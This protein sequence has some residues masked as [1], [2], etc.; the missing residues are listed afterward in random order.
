MLFNTFQFAIFLAVVLAGYRAVPRDRRASLLLAA[1]LVFYAFWIPAYLLLMLADVGVNY[2]LLR[3]MVR[4]RRPRLI[5]ACSITFTLGLLA[6]FKY[7]AF[8]VQLAAPALDG[9]FGYAPQVPDVL[10]PLGISF[11]S[12]QII[13]LAVDTYRGAR[14]PV[15][16]LGRYALF[17]SF[18]PQLI[19]GPI[20]R[21]DQLLPQLAR[22]GE[23]TPERN[24]RGLWLITSGLAKKVVLADFLIAGFVD[25]VFQEP[26]VGSGAFHL[27]AVYSFAFQIYFDFSG[28]TDMARGIA[29]LLGFELPKNFTEPYLSRNP[30]ELWERWHITL[31]S[32]LRDYLY[33]PLGGN[34][35]GRN[36]T[37]RNLMVTMLLGGLWHGAGWNF[38]IWGGIHGVL[39]AGHR[40]WVGRRPSG[41]DPIV[42]R[43]VLKIGL[44]FQGICFAWVFFRART[45]SD[46]L[47]V[48]ESI[49]TGSYGDWPLLQ[50]GVVI[51]CCG[52]HCAERLLR[53]RLPAV[54][55]A[56]GRRCWGAFAEAVVMGVVL[57]LAVVV[58]D[59][60]G[61]FIYF[62]F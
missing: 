62:Q 10:L 29:L 16:S 45:L 36:Q 20:L 22:G 58:G 55:E 32:W 24:R 13:A 17:V 19:A 35:G 7:A 40:A 8:A 21:G 37:Y 59:T 52:L 42:A 38:V 49:V 33:I 60:G 6:F 23:L 3:V 57:G 26:G 5:L 46:A 56:L 34:R 18:F 39:L 47:Q 53:T 54:R 43:D 51:L 25:T 30:A 41:Q 2:A 28:Y 61:E 27:V 48:L 31:S 4:S 1:S 15:R 50:S 12:F 44:L 9:L 11:Y 14:E